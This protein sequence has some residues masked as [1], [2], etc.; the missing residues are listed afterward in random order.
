MCCAVSD[1]HTPTIKSFDHFLSIM[2]RDPCETSKAQQIHAKVGMGCA[3]EQ[4]SA[5]QDYL[6][7]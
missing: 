5:R 7:H 1:S 2:P 4:S 3:E 6:K